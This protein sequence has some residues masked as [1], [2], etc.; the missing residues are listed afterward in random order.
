VQPGSAVKPPVACRRRANGANLGNDVAMLPV[1]TVTLLFSDIEA[2][3]ALVRR[4]GENYDA[5]LA[6]HFAIL[7]SAIAQHG[8][9][10]VNTDGDAMFAVFPDATEAM[11]ACVTAQ[12]ALASH[13]WPPDAAP[14]VRMGLHT[15]DVRR[16]GRDYVGLAVHQA[17]R[18]AAVA[19]GGQVV[20]SAT[21]RSACDLAEAKIALVDLG[22]W[23]VRDFDEAQRL[24]QVTGDGLAEDFPALR[25]MP[26]E[27]HNLPVPR[28]SFVGRERDLEALQKRVAAERIVTVV[29]TGGIGKTRV[30]CELARRLAP[31]FRDGATAVFLATI[32]DSALVPV[33]V[34]EA[35]G[36]REEPGK[37]LS[38]TIAAAIARREAVVVLDNCE[39][40]VGA[41]AGLVDEIMRHPG[42][43]VVVATSRRPLDLPGESVFSLGCLEVPDANLPAEALAGAAAIR[44]FVERGQV[45]QPGFALDD[46]VAPVVARICAQLEGL[47]LAIELAAAR[48]RT[49][50]IGDIEA[51][52]GHRLTLLTSTSRAAESRQRSLRAT[53][54][55]SYEMLDDAERVLMARLS[56]FPAGVTISTAETVCAFEPLRSDEMLDLLGSLVDKSILRVATAGSEA[57][58]S[59]LETLREYATEK[60]HGGR[61]QV[62]LTQRMTRWVTELVEDGALRLRTDDAKAVLSLLDTEHDNLL[63]ALAAA[64]TDAS[65][66]EPT[67]QIALG[68]CPYWR[69]TGQWAHGAQ[70]LEKLP[71]PADIATRAEL[72]HWRGAFAYAMGRLLDAVEHYRCAAADARSVASSALEARALVDL[73]TALQASGDTEGELARSAEAAALTETIAE[74]VVRAEILCATAGHAI[75]GVIAPG[76]M[77]IASESLTVARAAGDRRLEAIALGVMATAHADAGDEAEARRV[78]EA[79]LDMAR[80]LGDSGLEAEILYLLAHDNRMLSQLDEASER[81][82]EALALARRLGARQVEARS[83][84]KLGNIAYAKRDY[85]ASL[86]C[87][88]QALELA[89]ELG[90]RAL[91]AKTLWDLGY[92]AACAGDHALAESSYADG[93][94]RT[95][96]VPNSDAQ[97][98]P[99]LRAVGALHAARGN[100]DD[101]LRWYQELLDAARAAGGQA[102]VADALRRLGEVSLS[103]GDIA[104]ARS[105]ID[106]ATEVAARISPR[107]LHLVWLAQVALSLELSDTRAAAGYLAHAVDALEGTATA[108]QPKSPAPTSTAPDSRLLLYTLWTAAELASITD[109]DAVAALLRDARDIETAEEGPLWWVSLAV[110]ERVERAALIVEGAGTASEPAVARPPR[111]ASEVIEGIRQVASSLLAAESAETS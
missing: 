40:V 11:E 101:A 28:T 16:G 31:R 99:W 35:L 62:E 69:A 60:L 2:S 3:T 81:C 33:R 32:E 39:H 41:V 54:D 13:A 108:A 23:S 89:T 51:R 91:E 76:G 14:R 8:G 103:R 19:H 1:G 66:V 80:R 42:E 21:T 102:A 36:L 24:F 96:V 75:G 10:E 72:T 59:M 83:V 17:A 37:A 29:G 73:A 104:Q 109:R 65:M 106:Q 97:Q 110:R 7:R 67:L 18:V 26:A 57:R 46:G 82:N 84:G 92:T 77:K 48:L 43:T 53:I 6:D 61:D 78:H 5:L 20:C 4:L 71:E 100:R 94:A 95:R 88:R 52:L 45:A 74:E 34:A 15:G 47:P 58:Y 93:L 90:D 86:E 105:L 27:A 12:R 9:V 49:M 44:L 50:S 87:L 64:S 68:L 79:Q 56:A 107:G 55:W 25:A 85:D 22:L 38:E 70:V 111:T 63:A 30:A 98:L